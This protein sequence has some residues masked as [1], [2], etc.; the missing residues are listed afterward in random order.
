MEALVGLLVVLLV[1]GLL[2]VFVIQP[3]MGARRARERLAQETANVV[4]TNCKE[5]VGAVPGS[6]PPVLVTGQAVIAGNPLVRQLGTLRRIFGG[7]VGLFTSLSV[8]ASHLAVLRMVQE[9][10]RLG[11]NAVG[12]VRI[13]T[14]DLGEAFGKGKTVLV[15]VVAYGTAYDVQE[16]PG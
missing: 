12:N 11:Y 14:S 16:Q 1:V 8:W 9:A 3:G 7:E 15:E 4:I 6:K 2:V 10:K 13:E 5:L